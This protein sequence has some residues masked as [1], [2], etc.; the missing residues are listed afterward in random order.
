[1]PAPLIGGTETILLAEDNQSIRDLTR[2]ILEKFG[3]RVI[4]ARDREDAIE[5]LWEC[6]K[7]IQLLLLDVVMP[8]KNGREVFET[9]QQCPPGI[10][11]LFM[12]GWLYRGYYRY[13]P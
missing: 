11:A 6:G 8:K 2:T 9:I 4:E 3:Y 10:R 7:E 12:S 5:K 1:M 13:Y